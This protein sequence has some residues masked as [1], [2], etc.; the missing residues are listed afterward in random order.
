MA[1]SV[2]DEMQARIDTAQSSISKTR[3]TIDLLGGVAMG[4]GIVW[5]IW[6]AFR[7]PP[8][9]AAKPGERT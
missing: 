3:R 7:R 5:A 6:A 1:S 2:L 4:V 9:E 8:V